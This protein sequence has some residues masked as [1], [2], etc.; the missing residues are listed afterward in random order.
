M[1][2]ALLVACVDAAVT[3]NKKQRRDI[4]AAGTAS[5]KAHLLL[6]DAKSW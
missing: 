2:H 6:V 4:C 3:F 1:H 5:H